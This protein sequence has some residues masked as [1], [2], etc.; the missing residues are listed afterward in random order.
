MVVLDNTILSNLARVGRADLIGQL[1]AETACTTVAVMKEHAAA[2]ESGVHPQ[3]SWAGLFVTELTEEEEVTRA[4]LPPR[5]GQGERACIAVARHRK[6]VLVT[7]DLDA[8][9][10]ATRM[11]VAVTGTVG[12]LVLCVQQGLISLGEGNDLLKRMIDGTYRA[13]VDRLDGLLP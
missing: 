13:P 7:D 4:A 6:G 9:K 2:V 11:E 10:T 8:R 3:G 5:L 1:W 12:V